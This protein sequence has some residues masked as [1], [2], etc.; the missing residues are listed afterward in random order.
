MWKIFTKKKPRRTKST[1]PRRCYYT[2]LKPCPFCGGK[3]EMWCIDY[4]EKQYSKESKY[5]WYETKNH[6]VLCPKSNHCPIHPKTGDHY[7]THE[8]AARAWNK[9]GIDQ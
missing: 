5:F 9:R 8:G 7:T 6:Q 4:G 1:K 2:E 3:A